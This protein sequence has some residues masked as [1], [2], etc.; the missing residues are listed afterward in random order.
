MGAV[1]KKPRGYVN[2]GRGDGTSETKSP[3]EAGEGPYA[4]V[5][6]GPPTTSPMAHEPT[7]TRATRP[8]AHSP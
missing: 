4:A 6:I 1:Q 7:G 2:R 5:P 3:C 8:I